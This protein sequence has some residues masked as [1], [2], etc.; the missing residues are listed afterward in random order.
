MP[1]TQS[2]SGVIFR[3]DSRLRLPGGQRQDTQQRRVVS[4]GTMLSQLF[5][6][7]ARTADRSQSCS[8]P[9]TT[10]PSVLETVSPPAGCRV[11]WL[12]EAVDDSRK[13][14]PCN[15]STL[16]EGSKTSSCGNRVPKISLCGQFDGCSFS[17]TTKLKHPNL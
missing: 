1:E 13:M 6:T 7:A 9:K 3:C 2:S 10:K 8:P 16:Q 12:L 4:C 17:S 11:S 15:E 14:H 5:L